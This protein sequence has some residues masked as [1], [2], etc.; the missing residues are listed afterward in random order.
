[1][2]VVMESLLKISQVQT[3]LDSLIVAHTY[4]LENAGDAPSHNKVDHIQALCHALG[5]HCRQV[6]PPLSVVAFVGSAA[7]QIR[8]LCK[9]EQALN[10]ANLSHNA[11][12][13][14]P[15]HCYRSPPMLQQLHPTLLRTVPMKAQRS[16]SFSSPVKSKSP[17]KT[18]TNVTLSRSPVKQAPSVSQASHKIGTKWSPVNQHMTPFVG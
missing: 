8:H 5:I 9:V 7:E 17:L 15:L 11:K 13:S 4:G 14:P 12:D 3:H 2:Q 10:K 18:P 6:H 16:L 1:M